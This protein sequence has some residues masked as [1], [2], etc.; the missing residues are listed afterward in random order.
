MS[1]KNFF[2]KKGR[3]PRVAAALFD[4]LIS[5]LH[6]NK[7]S[8]LGA[9]PFFKTSFLHPPPFLPFFPTAKHFCP[10]ALLLL[11]PF[12]SRN[13]PSAAAK[14]ERKKLF[15]APFPLSPSLSAPL[16]RGGRRRRKK[17]GR[18]EGG[19]QQGVGLSA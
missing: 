14:D 17:G 12:R 9:S 16:S 10:L 8:S 6:P 1:K 18:G 13:F 19:L 4:R 15:D 11:P 2:K 7:K 3:R 5:L